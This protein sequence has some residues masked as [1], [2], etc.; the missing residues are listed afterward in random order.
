MTRVLLRGCQLSFPFVRQVLDPAIVY[1]GDGKN[2]LTT[3]TRQAADA[4][5]GGSAAIAYQGNPARYFG[6]GQIAVIVGIGVNHDKF[7]GELARY[8][9]I[10]SPAFFGSKIRTMSTGIAGEHPGH[11]IGLRIDDNYRLTHIRDH[12]GAAIGRDG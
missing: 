11:G 7:I 6:V 2:P 4:I 1:I 5:I 12:Y 10:V 9:G 8:I 3:V